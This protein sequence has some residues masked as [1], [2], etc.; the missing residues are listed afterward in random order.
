MKKLTI[1]DLELGGG[2]PKICIPLTGKS[3]EEI[4]KEARNAEELPCQLVEWR[5]DYMLAELNNMTSRQKGDELKRVLKYLRMELELPII[6]TIRTKKEGGQVELSKKEYFFI[7]RMIA[8]AGIADIIDIEAFDAPE[9]VDERSI[10]R[11]ITLAHR[12]HTHVLLSNHDFEETPDLV[13][14]MT[15]F[16]V[17]QDLGADLMKMAVMPKKEEDVFCLLEVAALMRDTYGEIPFIAI[18]MGQIGATTRICGGEFGSVITFASGIKT[19]APG[20]MDAVT[21][22]NFLVQYYQEGKKDTE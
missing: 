11:F 1:G 8:E 3:Q 14:M 21:L 15:R 17:M 22:Q 5:A 18:A 4:L 9:Q 12:Y 2:M 20:Q 13:E 7:N 10:R 6:F 16:F 19:S